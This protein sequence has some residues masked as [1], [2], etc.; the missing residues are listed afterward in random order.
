MSQIILKK[1][2]VSAKVPAVSDLAYGELALN[3]ADGIL[4][5][6]TS[7]DAISGIRVSYSNLTGTVPT[8]NQNTTGNAGTVTNGVYLTT[9]QTLTNKRIQ[10]RVQPIT[11]ASGS[12]TQAWNSDSYDQ[13]NLSLSNTATVTLSLDSGTPTDG[14]KIMFRI[15]DDGTARTFA[16]ISS[17][18]NCFRNVGTGITLNSTAT[19]ANKLTYVGCV[20]NS[21]GTGT[22]D[23]VAFGQEA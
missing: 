14:Q 12:T 11:V 22:W 2:N 10:P 16:L 4:Y 20:Y 7:A 9:A 1:S 21:S 8:W 17:G 13:I 18:T 6:R 23:V 19:T 5:Y 15:K 3:Y